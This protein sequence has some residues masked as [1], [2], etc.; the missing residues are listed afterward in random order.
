[1]A[2]WNYAGYKWRLVYDRGDLFMQ[3]WRGGIWATPA[4]AKLARASY[5][6]AVY[7]RRRRFQTKFLFLCLLIFLLA[8]LIAKL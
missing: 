2:Q 6:A 1:M 7:P 4:D 3:E 8:I 5:L